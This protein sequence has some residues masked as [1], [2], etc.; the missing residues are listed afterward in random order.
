MNDVSLA[1]LEDDTVILSHY[2][3]GAQAA[4]LARRD[5][6]SSSFTLETVFGGS[7]ISGESDFAAIGGVG[8]LLS[9][10]RYG[11][12]ATGGDFLVAF[13]AAGAS[14]FSWSVLSTDYTPGYR[15]AVALEP[16]GVGHAVYQYASSGSPNWGTVHYRRR[17]PSGTWGPV[18]LVHKNSS[19]DEIAGRSLDIAVDDAGVVHVAYNETTKNQV[20]YA[21]RPPSGGWTHELIGTGGGFGVAIAVRGTT[22]KVAMAG[23]NGLRV[24]TRTGA[25]SWAVSTVDGT[26]FTS[27]AYPSVA[28]DP[29]GRPQIAYA[30][31]AALEHGYQP[32]GSSSWQLSAILNAPTRSTSLATDAHGG[33]HV[34][35]LD[36]SYVGG[37]N[38][39]PRHAY[40]CLY[41]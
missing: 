6:G 40:R 4:S 36:Q 18:E 9:Q 34:G 21:R 24:A 39:R 10:H 27:N 1:L 13:R 37:T 41:P 38:G 2:S 8:E 16:S 31:D 22:V 28:I 14:S 17:P 23:T 29:L 20:W 26:P 35:F 11:S 15:S 33:V 7:P 3:S 12:G 5:P 25:A 19:P 32:T 30:T